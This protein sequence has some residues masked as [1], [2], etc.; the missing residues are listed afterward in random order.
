MG[1]YI[2][3]PSSD[4]FDFNIRPPSPIQSLPLLAGQNSIQE[5][6]VMYFFEHVSKTNLPF[7]SNALTN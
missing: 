1:L 4:Q 7:S 3:Q 2:A 6:H 5:S